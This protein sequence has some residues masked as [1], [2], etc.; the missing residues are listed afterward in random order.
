[1]LTL[2]TFFKISILSLIGFSPPLLAQDMPRTVIGNSGNYY[3]HL[4]FGNLHYTVGEVAVDYHSSSITLAEGFHHAY[5]DLVV[6]T[7]EVFPEQWD[8]QV[9]PNPTAERIHVNLP[10]ETFT[11]LQLFNHLGQ[12]VY[13]KETNSTSVDIDMSNL[14]SGAFWLTLNDANG[15]QASLQVQKIAF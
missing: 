13:K 12:L 11:H 15:R 9:Y 4:L 3:Q 2:K 8:I 10:D 5:Y 6:D 14:P 1:M 7:K